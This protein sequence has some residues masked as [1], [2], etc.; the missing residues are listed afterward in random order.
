MIENGIMYGQ[1]EIASVP[2]AAVKMTATSRNGTGVDAVSNAD[3]K[4]DGRE[5]SNRRED[6]QVRPFEPSHHDGKV[7]SEGIDEHDDQEC[8]QSA[9]QIRN[10]RYALSRTSPSH[11]R[12][13]QQAPSRV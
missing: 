8:E 5:S 11:F 9:S 4:R 13:S 12:T 6:E 10:P 3:G 7:L 2:K 1:N